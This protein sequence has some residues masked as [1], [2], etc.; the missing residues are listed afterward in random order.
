MIELKRNSTQ[1]LKDILECMTE[2]KILSQIERT[3]RLSFD[4]ATILVKELERKGFVNNFTE[5]N[6]SKYQLSSSGLEFLNFLRIWC[7]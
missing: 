2:K 5:E 7:D 1:I 4:V 3:S 6:R